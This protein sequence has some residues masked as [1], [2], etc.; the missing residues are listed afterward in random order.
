M[1]ENLWYTIK[2]IAYKTIMVMIHMGLIIYMV[3]VILIRGT[4]MFPP[5]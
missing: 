4:N 3:R 1:I 2:T 5:S